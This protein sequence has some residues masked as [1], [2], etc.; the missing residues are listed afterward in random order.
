MEKLLG[1][2]D[3]PIPALR[4]VRPDVPEELE[5]I[6]RRMVAKKPERRIRRW[7]T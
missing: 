1:H 4:E 3:Q 5:A 7:P 2:R 6:F